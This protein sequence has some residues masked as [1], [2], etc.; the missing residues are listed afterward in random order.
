MI[1]TLD[2]RSVDMN[3]QQLLR[4]VRHRLS[5][6]GDVSDTY[7]YAK[8]TEDRFENIDLPPEM[9]YQLDYAAR[10][11][12]PRPVP[13]NTRLLW[14]KKGIARIM[15]VYTTPQVEYNATVFRLI[16]SVIDVLRECLR[17]F[18]Y[19]RKA[20]VQ[21]VRRL[22]NV[23]ENQIVID[24][25]RRRHEENEA[26][27]RE[28]QRQIDA[29]RERIEQIE[30]VNRFTDFRVAEL[31]NLKE[32]LQIALS[33][34]KVLRA[35]LSQISTPTSTSSSQESSLTSSSTS[36]VS[37]SEDIYNHTLYFPYL[38]ADR[39]IEA[40]IRRR[41]KQYIHFFTDMP[42]ACKGKIVDIG[43][44]RGEFLDLGKS[45]GLDVIGT[46][47]NQDMVSH[48]E[49]KGHTVHC[50]NAH[51]YLRQCP[52]ESL[53]GIIT[54]QVIE[55]MPAHAILSFL[56]LC[57]E[58][59]QPGGRLIIETPNPRSLAAIS[60]FTRDFTHTKLFH[61]KTVEF[62]LEQLGFRSVEIE[63]KNPAPVQLSYEE[64]QDAEVRAN[65]EK[66]NDVV[67]GHLD[68]TIYA[69]K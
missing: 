26:S 45:A 10:I 65:F 63:E 23:E 42:Q 50:L 53:R 48:C 37:A 54:C 30:D 21:L 55:H 22:E 34:N 7:S 15:R 56:T 4:H 8:D 28:L 62:V 12:D 19:F 58:A 1:E 51:A 5:D 20:E 32:K 31:E 29:H 49:E 3:I 68:Y 13:G 38:N 44:G 69:E 9:Y 57:G 39:G 52:Q 59:L 66:L 46:D 61:Q 18:E 40:E 35:R 17:V 11:Y 60:L 6:T 2:I 24:G 67:F 33:E 43:C 14:L 27:M 47:L 25:L 36:D 41:Q 16:S 64:I